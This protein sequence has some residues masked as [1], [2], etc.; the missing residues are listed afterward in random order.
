MKRLFLAL[1]VLVLVL[2]LSAQENG[3]GSQGFSAGINLGSDLLPNP[4][5]PTVF[6][7]W[8]KLGFQPDLS[9]GKFGIGLDLTLRFKLYPNSDTPIEI[10]TPD[11]IPQDGKTIFD[12][13]LPKIMYVR[14]GL[15]GVDPFYAKLG[16]IPD[17]SL[18]NGLIVSDYSNTRFLPET[19]I[20]GLQVGVDGSLFKV[21]YFGIE[22]LTGNLSQLDVIG[23]RVYIR[24]L[25]F[26]GSSILGRLQ[27]GATAVVD[28]DPLLYIPAADIGLYPASKL[29][30]VAG[31]DVTLPIITGNIFSLTTF[32]EG[33]REMNNA[34]GAIVGVS[35]KLISFINYGAQFRYLQEGFI[36]SYFDSN[37]DLYR[38]DRFTYVET[39]VPGDF[40]PGWLA[41]LGFSMFSNKLTFGALMDG[42]FAAAPLASS[43]D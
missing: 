4:D 30:Y 20:F 33:A 17:F 19:R 43:N 23:G 41:S 42:P 1:A 10:Y 8:S 21:P 37:Y 40:V 6:S 29:V 36:P 15:R 5:D 32:V 25:A 34:L 13:Y 2:P 12:V 7:S 39:T 9:I 38:G 16:S 31:A 26:M 28:R 22:A 24:P 3:S 27:V 11:W 35:G 18:G 14:Y